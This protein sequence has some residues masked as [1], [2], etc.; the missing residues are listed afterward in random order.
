MNVKNKIKLSFDLSAFLP[1]PFSKTGNQ[2]NG[3]ILG[4]SILPYYW[5][6][7][8]NRK[9][10]IAMINNI[11][12]ALQI[13][14]EENMNNA[15]H[16]FPF[17][18]KHGKS[19][20]NDEDITNLLYK[21]LQCSNRVKLFPYQ[22]DPIKT[23][24]EMVKCDAVLGMRYHASMFACFV[25]KPL[26]MINYQTKCT[27]LARDFQLSKNAIISP[28]K[29]LDGTLDRHIKN[30]LKNPEEFI[31]KRSLESLQKRNFLFDGEMLESLS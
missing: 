4:V 14:L 6:Y 17:Q 23:I 21:K 26:I 20:Q 22:P 10:D 31:A 2:N 8:S 29:I 30:L 16:L 25:K 5:V 7:Q 27:S 15:I 9:R 19:L 28:D 13:W 18:G 3:K 24:S 1:I 11:T 12:R